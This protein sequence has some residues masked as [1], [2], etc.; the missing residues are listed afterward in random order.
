MEELAAY[1]TETPSDCQWKAEAFCVAKFSVDDRWYRGRI[2][3]QLEDNTYEVSVTFPGDRMGKGF[4]V[5]QGIAEL[6]LCLP[7]PG[8]VSWLLL[9]YQRSYLC[10]SIPV[11]HRPS[12]TPRHCSL[13]W[14]ALV[15]SDQMV[16]CCFS[17]ASV[18]RLQLLQGRPLFL[19]PCRFQVRI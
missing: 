17:C 7:W 14:A 11:E 10:P 19:F 5:K 12:T 6:L 2:N 18:S 13:F 8:Y 9:I 4:V 1:E 16:P 3:R 15:I